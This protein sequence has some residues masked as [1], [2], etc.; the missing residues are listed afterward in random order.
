M[1]HEGVRRRPNYGDA[2]TGGV[3]AGGSVQNVNLNIDR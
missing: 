1:S 3:C 2:G